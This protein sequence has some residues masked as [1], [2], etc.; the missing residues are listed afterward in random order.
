PAYVAEPQETLRLGRYYLITRRALFDAGRRPIGVLSAGIDMTE[1]R[2][3][4]EA[5]ATEQRRLA[6]VVHAAKVGILDWD[7]VHRT[8]YYSPR[9]KEILGYPPDA[10]TSGWPDYFDMVHPEDRDR[11][12]ASFHDHIVASRSEFHDHIDYRLRR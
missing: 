10:D 7:G 9:F 6:L 8:A 5:I 4:E 2:A 11:V 12:K 1:R 3:M